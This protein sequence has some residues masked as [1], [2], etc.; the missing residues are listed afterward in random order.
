MNNYFIYLL[1]S[2]DKQKTYTGFTDNIENRIKK[3]KTK[4]VRT[5]KNFGDFSYIILEKVL[6]DDRL[7]R[8]AEKYWKSAS[9][10]R[11]IKEILKSKED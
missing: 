10:R 9:G 3:H 7:A 2:Q 1:I 5:T 11:R 8:E 4:G 6:P